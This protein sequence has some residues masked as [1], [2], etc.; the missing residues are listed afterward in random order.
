MNGLQSVVPR[1]VLFAALFIFLS[2]AWLS[3]Q[4]S[5]R[6]ANP[7]WPLPAWQPACPPQVINGR[8]G[9]GSADYPSTSGVQLGRLNRNGVASACNAPKTCSL[10]INTGARAYDAYTF[11]NNSGAQVCATVTLTLPQQIGTNYQANSY[12]SSFDP[13]NIC[14][15]YLADPGVSSATLSQPIVYSHNVPAG[16]TFVVAVQTT[17]PGEIDGSYQLKVEGLPNCANVCALNCPANLSAATTGNAATVNYALPTPAGNCQNASA[18][19]C[20]PP[21]GSSFA[22]GTTPVNCS[23][24]DANNNPIGCS[25]NVSVN[26]LSAAISEPAGCLA[27]G[28]VVNASLTLT[29]NAASAQTVTAAASLPPQLLALSGRCSS[30]IGGISTAGNCNVAS[31]SSVVFA[32]TLGA[33]QTATVS[34]P[35]QVADS[36]LKGTP[37]CIN[38]S[39]S[40]NGGP[41]ATA[42][43]CVTVTCDPV[44]E[45]RLLPTQFSG[46]DGRAGSILIFPI[47]TS[48][49][50]NAQSQNTRLSMT[51]L[52]PARSANAH[53]FLIDASSCEVRDAFVCL[54]PNQTTAFMASDIDPGTTGFL[55]VVAV[56]RQGCPINFNQLIGDEYVK[57]TS[58]HAAN[59]GAD[60]IPA[61]AGGLAACNISGANSTT[62]ALR[63]D[64]ISYA[65]LPRIVAA[66]GIG[67]RADG[68]EML[69][70]LNRIG[71]NLATGGTTVSAMTSLVYD[72]AE[73]SYGLTFSLT[74]QYR[75]SVWTST[76]ATPHFD[77][78]IPPGR[79]GWAKYYS[80]ADEAFLGA[81]INF[82]QNST[83]QANAFN[84]G[85][86]LHKLSYTAS[87]VYII[88]VTPPN[89]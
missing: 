61:I 30:T 71:G 42:Q 45:G 27:A 23:A 21:S 43:S 53:L 54:T 62:A 7:A 40:F 58:G 73:N 20:A 56:D 81:T 84:A 68:N 60:A 35:A 29:N 16:A 36:A 18:V 8:L 51:N 37:L 78:V 82:N 74:C 57:L 41:S 70:I 17:N 15:N 75:G 64:G 13:N 31:P 50:S 38:T 19:T 22:V 12:L 88:P 39:A 52:D 28:S 49:A 3:Q 4:K 10:G 79:S 85:H 55:V 33:G 86:N 76:R 66:D 14:A 9:S 1:A 59:L 6:S 25:F 2:L 44:G 24:R 77:T 83:E 11:K 69:L 34:Y 46:S 87:A 5:V 72:D 65:P 63:F 47:Y 26:K 48:A 32:A 89:C 67:S 80:N